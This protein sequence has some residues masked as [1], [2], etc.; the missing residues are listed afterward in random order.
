MKPIYQ[1]YKTIL[2]IAF[3]A[4][5]FYGW[6]NVLWVKTCSVM[7]NAFLDKENTF[8]RMEKEVLDSD[9]D[10]SNG[11]YLYI[12]VPQVNRDNLF[13]LIHICESAER[14]FHKLGLEV[15]VSSLS[16]MVD[17]ETENLDTFIS[18]ERLM[19]EPFDDWYKRVSV[20]KEVSGKLMG[21]RTGRRMP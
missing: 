6:S 18:R 13:C 9:L 2:L 17:Y 1:N 21:R 11:V 19:S 16:T 15:G 4:V 10:L 7:D 3:L 14:Y 12:R 5:I 8:V 20:R